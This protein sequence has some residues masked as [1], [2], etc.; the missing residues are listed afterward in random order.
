MDSRALNLLMRGMTVVTAVCERE[1][2]CE[3]GDCAILVM[4]VT[5]QVSDLQSR[6]PFAA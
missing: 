2:R 4:N 3:V 1:Y 6:L 5:V